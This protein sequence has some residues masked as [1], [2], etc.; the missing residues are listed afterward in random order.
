MLALAI[1]LLA[2]AERVSGFVVPSLAPAQGLRLSSSSSLHRPPSPPSSSLL[3][4]L[5]K[6]SR[7]CKCW[8]LQGMRSVRRAVCGCSMSSADSSYARSYARSRQTSP[9]LPCRANELAKE[10][11]E[12]NGVAELGV[13]VLMRGGQELPSL[14]ELSYEPKWNLYDEKVAFRDPLNNFNGIKKYQDNIQ[15]LKDSPLFTDGKMDLHK[16]EGG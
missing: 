9:D 1:C 13:Y 6:T 5:R 15:M 16:V 7:L 10:L 4:R 8:S 12:V 2:T 11:E 14:F 3:Q